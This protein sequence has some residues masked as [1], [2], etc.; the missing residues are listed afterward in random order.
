MKKGIKEVAAL[1]LGAVICLGLGA[2][3]SGMEDS[4]MDNGS[5]PSQPT[6]V[7]VKTGTIATDSWGYTG[8]VP[9]QVLAPSETEIA[10][11]ERT[12]LVDASHSVV[13]GIITT[14]IS[15]SRDLTTVAAAAQ[16]SAPAN[17]VSYVNLSM[18]PAR[19]AFPAL[20]VTV[21]VGAVSAGE[22]V[23]VYNYD[24]GTGRWISAQTAVVNSAG[25]I[26]FPVSQ[27]SLWGIFR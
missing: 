15:F 6:T 19:T 9:V 12:L 16:T 22:T 18:G 10:V 13:S 27:L 23:T 25:K 26:S 3:G 11:Q 24:T 8:S 5:N 20:T 1:L 2:C 17:F 14:K 4:F 7:S 21:D